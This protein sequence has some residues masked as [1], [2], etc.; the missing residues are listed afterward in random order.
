MP[1]L[2]ERAQCLKRLKRHFER[3]KLGSS[4]FNLDDEDDEDEDED[5][6][7]G[8]V[9][10]D[11]AQ[12]GAPRGVLKGL[13]IVCKAL[14]QTQ[15]RQNIFRGN[16]KQGPRAEMEQSSDLHVLL[17]H[18]LRDVVHA[19]LGEAAGVDVQLGSQVALRR[20]GQLPAEGR[21]DLLSPLLALRVGDEGQ[22]RLA[23]LPA[24]LRQVVVVRVAPGQHLL[25]LVVLGHHGEP[26]LAVLVLRRW[27]AAAALLAVP[28]DGELSNGRHR[29]EDQRLLALLRVALASGVTLGAR[30]D[31]GRCLTEGLANGLGA[32]EAGRL[33]H[34]DP[35]QRL[36]EDGAAALGVDVVVGL[37]AQQQRAEVGPLRLQLREGAVEV[38]VAVVQQQDLVG[39]LEV[40]QLAGDHDPRLGGH[41]FTDAPVEKL[42]D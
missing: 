9:H 4:R 19:V 28:H 22:H 25:H 15:R 7:Q 33:V 16:Q 30:H 20:D 41:E 18:V 38:A 23:P 36:G 17:V 39:P 8:P 3:L 11:V 40:L 24:Q 27:R 42:A 34:G 5:V 21:L 26:P 35:A 10:G 32:A 31:N 13:P 29:V 1:D 2:C 37:Q 14:L 6:D 12:V